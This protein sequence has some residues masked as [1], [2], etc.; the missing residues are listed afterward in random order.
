MLYP[1]LSF[2]ICSFLHLG[3]CKSCF[4]QH[5]TY[6]CAWF[7]TLQSCRGHSFLQHQWRLQLSVKQ[8]AS[9][10]LPLLLY[11]LKKYPPTSKSPQAFSFESFLWNTTDE[12]LPHGQTPQY[13][14]N[15]YTLIFKVQSQCVIFPENLKEGFAQSLTIIYL[16]NVCAVQWFTYMPPP[17]ESELQ[18]SSSRKVSSLGHP[19]STSWMVADPYIGNYCI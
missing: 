3:Y 17:T 7:Y 9:A 8:S 11:W 6:E 13:P 10:D 1:A 5:L 18:T 14:W 2:W 12:V 4:L 16:N 19:S 15:N